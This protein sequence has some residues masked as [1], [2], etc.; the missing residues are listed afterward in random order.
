LDNQVLGLANH[1]RAFAGG[2]RVV[3][4]AL[5][6]PQPELLETAD[7]VAGKRLVREVVEPKAASG[8]SSTPTG[9]KP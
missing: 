2:E 9:G 7:L 1:R 4:C 6:C 8:V 5:A 3:E